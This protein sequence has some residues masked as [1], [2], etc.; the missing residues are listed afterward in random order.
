[1]KKKYTLGS[2]YILFAFVAL[3]FSACS[4]N[5]PEIA[6]LSCDT[7]NSEPIEADE[8]RI[9]VEEFTGVRCSN[10]PKATA[11]L[12]DQVDRHGKD[13]II[14]VAI[15]TGFFARPLT[16]SR[17]DFNVE[18][19]DA[20]RAFLGNPSAYPSATFNRSLFDDYNSVQ[21]DA[22][23][24]W[25][26]LIGQELGKKT[27]INL[28]LTNTYDPS[29]KQLKAKVRLTPL[30][31]INDVL[32]ISIM[33]T[34]SNIVDVQK[35]PPPIEKQD[36]YVHNHVLR[37]MMTPPTGSVITEPLK[38][39]QTIELE[40]TQ[41]VKDEWNVGELDVVAV[42]HYNQPDNQSVV[43]AVDATVAQ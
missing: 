34:E 24:E 32:S 38:R 40:F 43:Q 17:Y 31:D 33:V 9:L 12:K 22:P 35:F 10:C 2:F 27:I 23:D 8:R 1:M 14:L 37:D 25:P 29:T 16:E 30:Q 15:H 6:C 11:T 4:E 18:E 41:V 21:V 42:V 19:A 13:R 26:G 39:E 20:L 5:S 28:S 3:I 7:N 36:D